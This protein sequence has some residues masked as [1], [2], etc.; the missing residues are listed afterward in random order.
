MRVEELF[1]VV[2][3]K[4][5]GRVLR[6]KLCL[7][8]YGKEFI[9]VGKADA[10]RHLQAHEMHKEALYEEKPFKP[11]IEKRIALKKG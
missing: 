10:E 4:G 3:R 5:L 9:V 2:E 11:K 1:E 6:C 8:R 7:R